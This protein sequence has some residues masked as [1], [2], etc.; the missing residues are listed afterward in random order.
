PAKLLAN[1]IFVADPAS[2]AGLFVAA[3]D[4]NGDGF[5]DIVATSDPTLGSGSE[6]RVLSGAD[7]DRQNPTPA[8][9][10]DFAVAG[11]DPTGGLRVGTTDIDGDGRAEV[12]VGS[13]ARQPS[14]VQVYL[15]RDLAP[16][17]GPAP[18]VLDPVGGAVL[19]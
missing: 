15:G 8:L 5:A 2:R 4:V 10:A 13:G 6:L 18:Q 14:S 3:G 1:D 17:P 19:T 11:F 12:V 16:G 7:L 9:L